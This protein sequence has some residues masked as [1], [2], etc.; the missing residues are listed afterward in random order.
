MKQ[1]TVDSLT[2]HTKDEYE[3]AQYTRE[4]NKQKKK[5]DEEQTLKNQIFIQC[6]TPLLKGIFVQLWKNWQM[7]DF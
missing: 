2:S 4:Q 7:V 6:L 3:K 5:R 1:V